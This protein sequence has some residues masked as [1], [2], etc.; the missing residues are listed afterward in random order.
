MIDIYFIRHGETGGNL[1]KRHQA[2]QTRLTPEGKEQALSLVPVIEKINPTHVLSSTRV[3]ALQTAN[4]ATEGLDLIPQTSET[5]VE[6]KRPDSIYG[7]HHKSVR[8]MWYLIAWYFGF[9]GGDGSNGDGESY[10]AFRERIAQAQ[11]ELAVLPD[12]S[13]VVVVSHSV[14]ISFL[15][16][17]LCDSTPVSFTQA[18]GLFRNILSLRNASVTHVQYNPDAQP[19]TCAWELITYNQ[20]AHTDA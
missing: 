7:Y 10:K 16:A 13:R 3:R 1:A 18:W 6:L 9:L 8:S 17:H 20:H 15:I 11:V 5:L 2:E 12:N 4:I 19:N 14:F